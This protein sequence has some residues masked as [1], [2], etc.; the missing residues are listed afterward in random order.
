MLMIFEVDSYSIHRFMNEL[1]ELAA[2]DTA[3]FDRVY[4]ILGRT[5]VDIIK[6]GGYKISAIEVERHLLSHPSI[7]DVAVVGLP[8]LT[9]GQKV[10]AAVVLQP[11]RQLEMSELRAWASDRL[12]SYQI[13][14]V[15][16]IIDRMPRNLM[17]KVNKKQLV[18]QVFGKYLKN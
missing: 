18:P 11:S 9:W 15:V 6:S 16:E 17:G 4:R 5:S 2:G 14:T 7:A 12:P 1:S 8:D 13:P 3:F 10:A